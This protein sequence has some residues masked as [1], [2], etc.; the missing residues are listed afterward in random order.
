MTAETDGSCVKVSCDSSVSMALDGFNILLH[1]LRESHDLEVQK[2]QEKLQELTNKKGCSDTKRMEE[3]F[4]RN[5]QL[6]EQQRLLTD[7][8]K[9]LENRLR[10]G[11]CDRCTVTQDVAK[12][13][14]QEYETSQIQSL[15]HISI[16][17][18]EMNTMKK[19]NQRLR[20]EVRHLRVALEGQNGHSSSQNATPEVRQSADL[21]PSAMPHIL[22]AIRSINQPSEG[23]TAGLSIVKTETD[24]S[25]SFRVDDTLPERRDVRGLNG[26][27]SYESHKPLSMSTP[28]P[29]A[30]RPEHSTARGNTG[31]KRAN[32]VEMVGQQ[33]SPVAP[34]IP[35]PLLVQKDRPLSSSSSFSSSLSTSSS[36]PGDEKHSRHL[37]HA[38]VP[39]W[40]RPIK[41]ARLSLPWPLPEHSDW[42]TVATS[43]DDGLVSQSKHNLNLPRF[44]NLQ[45]YVQQN[46]SLGKAWLKPSHPPQASLTRSLS[47]EHGERP[48]AWVQD[49]DR[50]V[51]PHSWSQAVVQAE[52]VFGESLK[53]A[54]S[55]LDLSDPGRSKSIKSPQ[56]SKASPTLQDVYI[57]G[58]T[59]NR[60]TRTDSSPQS[61]ACPPST[62]ALPSSSSSTRPT[63]QQSQSPNNHNLKEEEQ[64]EKEEAEG[65]VDQKTGKD[66]EDRKVP[67]LT[68][69]LRP[70]V[71]L[72]ALNS[73]LQ[74]QL[75]SNGKFD[76]RKRNKASWSP[77]GPLSAVFHPDC[78][79]DDAL[80]GTGTEGQPVPKTWT[81]RL[82]SDCCPHGSS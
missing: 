35:H 37:V 46:S 33:C 6:R 78:N 21:S 1:K 8:I 28:I 52:M 26:K 32:S 63:S 19:E 64:P 71:L 44:P 30:L 72:E 70:V 59:S 5:Q 67:V 31:Q 11:L 4:N 69:S 17:A 51:A 15:Q 47:T 77:G 42:V 79:R 20:E 66:S 61:Q 12:R 80:T 54:D 75:F 48:T 24:H 2:W 41:S 43:V 76:V 16:L 56:D 40:P 49:R 3:L 9:Q 38:P 53:E 39:Y 58:E 36:L 73:G 25:L 45:T 74:K 81:E 29:Q 27:Q 22:T 62:P 55:P 60:T 18:G 68:I 7:N 65:K 13:R 34:T 82:P 14:Q 10:A 50:R 23:A 57:E